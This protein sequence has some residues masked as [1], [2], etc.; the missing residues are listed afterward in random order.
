[1]GRP[2]EASTLLKDGKD[3]VEIAQ[4]MGVSVASTIDYL[5]REVGRGV[6]KRSDVFFAIPLE[7]RRVIDVVLVQLQT[8]DNHIV[9]AHLHKVPHKLDSTLVNVC[10][11]LRDARV[12]RGDMYEYIADIELTL[13]GQIKRALIAAHGDTEKGWWRAVPLNVRQNCASRREEDEEPLEPYR[14]TQFID[15]SRILDKNWG[16]FSQVLPRA[17]SGDKRRFLDD[18][19]LRLNRIRNSVM[20]PVKEIPLAEE[21]FLAV[22]RFRDD[23][24]YSQ[25]RM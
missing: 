23:I 6:I 21:D 3:L 11:E 13:H 1:M 15:L 2:S 24:Q 7:T 12:S 18:D 4:I 22:K 9:R 25:W 19:L 16:V 17:I 10:L 20:H 8:E 5:Y 14:Y